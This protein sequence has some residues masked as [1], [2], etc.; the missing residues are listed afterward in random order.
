MIF[1]KYIKH[2]ATS[3]S[4]FKKYIKNIVAST[5][6]FRKYIKNMVTSTSIFKKYIEKLTSMPIF[7]KYFD[8][9]GTRYHVMPNTR[10]LLSANNFPLNKSAMPH[11]LPKLSRY[12]R[13]YTVPHRK[14]E[15]SQRLKC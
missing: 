12:F 2:I 15:G 8:V 7:R 13:N 14:H 9:F 1:K 10:G 4:I 3:T 5:S 11:N 6:I